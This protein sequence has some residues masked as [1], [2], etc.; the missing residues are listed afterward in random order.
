PAAGYSPCEAKFFLGISHRFAHH[1]GEP[2]ETVPAGSGFLSV[3]TGKE[4]T[5]VKKLLTGLVICSFALLGCQGSSSSSKKTTSTTT[6]TTTVHEAT[7][8]KTETH[9]EKPK[10]ETKTETKTE[11]KTEKPPK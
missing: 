6:S 3:S 8:P 5:T 11:S 7:P 9:E 4:R 1:A 2:P 10:T